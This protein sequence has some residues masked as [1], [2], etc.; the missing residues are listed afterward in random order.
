MRERSKEIIPK[1]KQRR[2]RSL[3]LQGAIGESQS[4][5]RNIGKNKILCGYKK[6]FCNSE[7]PFIFSPTVHCTL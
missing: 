3:T 5:Y 2:L 6:L 7:A 1:M 4:W